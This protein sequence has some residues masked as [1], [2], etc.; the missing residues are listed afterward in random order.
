MP[1][2]LTHD[3]FA[4][5][6]IDDVRSVLPL[7]TGGELESI[8]PPTVALAPA[9]PMVAMLRITRSSACDP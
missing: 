9:S 2:I 4:R 1:A 7:S 8:S 3:L 5:G 6:V